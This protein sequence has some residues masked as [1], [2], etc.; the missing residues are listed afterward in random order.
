MLFL[1]SI[2]SRGKSAGPYSSSVRSDPVMPISGNRD[3]CHLPL[4]PNSSG[5]I[6]RSIRET[7]EPNL[8]SAI[9][10]I[11]PAVDARRALLVNSHPFLS[12]VSFPAS[13]GPAPVKRIVGAMPAGWCVHAGA[14]P[15][16]L[17]WGTGGKQSAYFPSPHNSPK[18]LHG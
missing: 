11:H 10:S 5:F 15:L 7:G 4:P 17:L 12:V 18:G 14:G 8:S 2:R 9:R 6:R 1:R 16:R 3:L 13:V